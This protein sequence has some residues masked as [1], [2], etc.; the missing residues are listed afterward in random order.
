MYQE[1]SAIS[2]KSWLEKQETRDQQESS[3]Y[4]IEKQQGATAL[5][6]DFEFENGNRLALPYPALQKL[7]Y[8]PSE[9]ILL[10]WGDEHM[11]IVGRNLGELYSLLLLHRVNS[12]REVSDRPS[13]RDSS[14]LFIR[15]IIRED[16]TW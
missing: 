10:E 8:K 4:T 9:G 5:M 13:P 15:Q 6:L 14:A 11:R 3:F 1:S 16:Q 7:D 12:I 2:G